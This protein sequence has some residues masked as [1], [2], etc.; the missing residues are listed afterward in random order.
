MPSPTTAFA[1]HTHHL[2]A[3]FT[4]ATP[5][6]PISYLFR[7]LADAPDADTGVRWGSLASLVSFAVV[8]ALS[9]SDYVA[10]R[11]GAC[12]VY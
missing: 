7:L 11:Y 9:S 2:H 6:L 5:S 4:P 10:V 3:L 8:R 12:L 1:P